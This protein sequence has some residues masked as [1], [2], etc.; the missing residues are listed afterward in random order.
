MIAGGAGGTGGT[1]GACILTLSFGD[2]GVYIAA[3]AGWCNTTSRVSTLKIWVCL[4]SSKG[5]SG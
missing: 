1:E 5:M 4:R 3:G 2:L